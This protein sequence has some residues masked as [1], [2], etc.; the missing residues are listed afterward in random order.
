MKRSS[1]RIGVSIAALGVCLSASA[2]VTK[3]TGNYGAWA[4]A[5]GPHSTITF[6]EFQYQAITTQYSDLG[7]L[8]TADELNSTLLS[9]PTFPEDG[10]GMDGNTII[11]LTFAEPIHAIGFHHPAYIGF[12]LWSGPNV[13]YTTEFF[14]TLQNRFGG[15]TSD[16]PFDRVWMLPANQDV[17]SVY[18][19]N[20]YFST[21]PAPGVAACLASALVAGG[22]RCRRRRPC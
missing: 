17:G 20:L 15:I 9:P 4:S 13:S 3:F 10:W 8:F 14:G 7:V 22:F 12:V 21:I 1:Q 19:D 11:E 5:A 6:A 16:Q 2:D 18:L